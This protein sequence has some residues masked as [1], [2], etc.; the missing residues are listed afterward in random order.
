MNVA[1]RAD[2][3]RRLE[4][5]ALDDDGAALPFSARLASENGWSRRFAARAIVEYKRFLLLAVAA[6]H[7]ACPSDE[8]DQVW[9]LHL[10]YT[11]SYWQDL[12]ESVL[13]RPLHHGPTRGGAEELQKYWELY[14]RTLASYQNFFGSPPPA[15]LWPPAA[16]RFGKHAEYRR[17]DLRRHW[18]LPKPRLPLFSRAKTA[19][20]G[21]WLLGLAFVPAASLNPFDLSGGEFLALYLLCY[22][23][24]LG[25]AWMIRR[26][27]LKAERAA[28]DHELNPYEVAV[29]VQNPQLAINAAITKLTAAEQLQVVR[30]DKKLLGISLRSQFHFQTDQPLSADASELEKALYRTAQQDGGATFAQLQK[31][32]ADEANDFLLDLRE[33]GLLTTPENE[34]GA[35]FWPALVLAALLALGVLKLAVGLMRGRPVLLLVLLC[36]GTLATLLV[37]ARKAHRTS[38]GQSVLEQYRTQYRHLKTPQAHEDPHYAALAVSLF[39]V[40]ALAGTPL[41]DLQ[42][43]WQQNYR[44]S[45]G[46]SGCGGGC[47]GGGCGG[48]CGGCGD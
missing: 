31:A 19:R 47:S 6:E 32:G 41:A 11:R 13:G 38:A 33:R 45:S 18:V 8:V 30:Q 24:S 39:G 5:L 26:A 14:E 3:W 34:T 36:L 1:E 37:F 27:Y 4:A 2:L 22:L 23:V 21:S 35:R 43:A 10:A 7:V 48:G 17:I 15:D 9:H 42:A 40:A 29:L 46:D 16:M 25:L 20:A 12:C 28:T 44:T